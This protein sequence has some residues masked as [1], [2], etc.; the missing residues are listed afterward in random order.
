MDAVNIED[1]KGGFPMRWMAP[2]VLK[3][4]IRFSFQSDVWSYGICIYEV[5][6]D[7]EKPWP[8]GDAR[9]IQKSIRT[10]KMP[11]MP[12]KT[13]K[14]L[15]SLVGNIW[16][17]DPNERPVITTIY[18]KTQALLKKTQPKCE[19]KDFTVNKLNG[20]KAIDFL[21]VKRTRGDREVDECDQTKESCEDRDRSTPNSEMSANHYCFKSIISR[22]IFLESYVKIYET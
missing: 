18:K 3:K 7:G 21:G 20:L 12:K 5:Y 10:L 13:P 19:P 9:T 14:E 4:P 16:V 22:A 8:E 17:K 6:N 15:K 11:E 2:E 1:P